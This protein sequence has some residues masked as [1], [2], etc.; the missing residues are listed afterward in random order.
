MVG[1]PE[2]VIYSLSFSPFYDITV[3]LSCV[4]ALRT[5]GFAPGACSRFIL[6]GQYTQVFILR[7]LAP[8]YGT[9]EGPNGR[10]LVWDSWYSPD[11]HLGTS[12]KLNMATSLWSRTKQKKL[13]LLMMMMMMMMMMMTMILEDDSSV[14]NWKSCQQSMGSPVASEKTGERGF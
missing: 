7:E 12:S 2:S 10:N 11:E 14:G 9:H 13:I 3:N 4:S 5:R 1:C 8:C 6:H